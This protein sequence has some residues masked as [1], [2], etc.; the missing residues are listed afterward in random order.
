MGRGWWE[1]FTAWLFR[2]GSGAS[3]CHVHTPQTPLMELYNVLFTKFSLLEPISW[4]YPNLYEFPVMNL[5]FLKLTFWPTKSCKT[6][7]NIYSTAALKLADLKLLVK[8]LFLELILR[9]LPALDIY[10][11]SNLSI[12]RLH[13]SQFRR[14][15][16]ENLQVGEGNHLQV[17]D[18]KQVSSGKCFEHC[19]CEHVVL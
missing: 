1:P 15:I 18:R 13:N 4:P 2:T 16:L 14:C 12:W 6:V 9:K 10:S 3:L 7:C 5:W 8:F 19:W 11:Q 17:P